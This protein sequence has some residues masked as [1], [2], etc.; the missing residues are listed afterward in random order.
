MKLTKIVLLGIALGVGACQL[1]LPERF[2][3]NAPVAHMLFGLGADGPVESDFR[4]A[5]ASEPR[6][7]AASGFS[8]S[9]FATDLPN[10]RFLRPTPNGGLL[11]SQPRSGSIVLLEP[12]RDGDGRSDGRRTAAESPSITLQTPELNRSAS[13]TYRLSSSHRAKSWLSSTARNV[14]TK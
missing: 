11:V 5:A 2:A 4:T 1:F 7:Q 14:A 12:D 9:I 8:I 13:R 3:V 10:A 6:I